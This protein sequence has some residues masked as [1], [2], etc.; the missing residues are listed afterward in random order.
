MHIKEVFGVQDD[1]ESHSDAELGD[2]D[3]KALPEAEM[4]RLIREPID[5]LPG[6]INLSRT[7]AWENIQPC[8][9]S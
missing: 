4:G 7:E 1:E 6:S 9:K 3:S 5:L 8:G 2:A